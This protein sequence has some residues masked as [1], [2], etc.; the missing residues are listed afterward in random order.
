[1]KN[2]TFVLVLLAVSLNFISCTKKKTEEASTVSFPPPVN[3]QR[4]VDCGNI[5]T[6]SMPAGT[7]DASAIE[8]TYKITSQMW[9]TSV[10]AAVTTPAQVI[11]RIQKSLALWE[12]VPRANLK[13]TYGGLAA[14][15]YAT[16]ADIPQD[17]ILYFNLNND[18]TNFAASGAGGLGSPFGAVSASSAYPGGHVTLNMKQDLSNANVNM[19]AHEVGH[20]IGLALHALSNDSVMTCGANGYDANEALAFAEQDRVWLMD[21]WP[22]PGLVTY[23]IRGRIL[24]GQGTQPTV[25]AVNIQNGHTYHSENVLVGDGSFEVPVGFPGEY[26]VFAKNDPRDVYSAST[27]PSWY[28]GDGSS[29]ND[30][31]AGGIVTVS[32]GAPIAT[33]VDFA[34]SSIVASSSLFYFALDTVDFE[35]YDKPNHS[36]LNPGEAASFQI[37]STNHTGIGWLESYGEKPD[38]SFSALVQREGGLVPT[39]EV[40]ICAGAPQGSRLVIMKLLDG[41]VQA[42][43]TGIHVGSG[44]MPN[45]FPG[46]PLDARDPS[47]TA[48]QIMRAR[49]D[50]GYDFSAWNPAYWF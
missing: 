1:M 25:F 15:G 49:I 11:A 18:G 36:F 37:A 42:G 26:R 33:G 13:F 38:Y 31:Y 44:T 2:F 48:E 39:A 8:I 19:I 40:S 27:L 21:V 14:S 34:M 3:T 23:K 35:T 17:G 43:L 9:D 47:I 30:P 45:I 12:S 5:E 16:V 28:V 41:S 22:A 4:T 32:T 20:A 46:K 6:Y 24:S 7:K 10:D 50:S 29:T